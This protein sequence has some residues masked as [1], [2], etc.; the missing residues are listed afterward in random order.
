MCDPVDLRMSIGAYNDN[1]WPPDVTWKPLLE[2]A[3]VG[4]LR[5]LQREDIDLEEMLEISGERIQIRRNDLQAY[6]ERIDNIIK[7]SS[8]WKFEDMIPVMKF[9]NFARAAEEND[10]ESWRR[11][12]TERR[13]AL[14]TIGRLQ[15]LL[16]LKKKANHNK[17]KNK[18]RAARKKELQQDKGTSG[19]GKEGETSG[20]IQGCL[21]SGSLFWR[22]MASRHA[23]GQD[24]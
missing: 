24:D 5:K 1:D 10:M 19:T 3:I 2:Y 6:R 21:G 14:I 23:S 12:D 15:K 18:N 8:N 17:N 16:G 13:S 11:L 9:I 20:P 4:H 7:S 22:H